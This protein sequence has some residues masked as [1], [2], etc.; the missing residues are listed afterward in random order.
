MELYNSTIGKILGIHGRMISGSKSGY[1]KHYPD[2]LVV[3]NSNMVVVTETG[4]SKVWFGD[5]DITLDREK[6]K[7]V[8]KEL[9]GTVFIIYEMD[10]R[11]ENENSPVLSRYVYSVDRDG[12]ETLGDSVSVYFEIGDEIK[13]RKNQ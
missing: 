2:N 10:G 3:F 9:D 4:A 6:L 8:A 11:F 1:R 12:V 7:Q 5:V 13:S